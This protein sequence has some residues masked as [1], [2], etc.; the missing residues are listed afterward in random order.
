MVQ[1]LIPNLSVLISNEFGLSSHPCT[2]YTKRNKETLSPHAC[3]RE[4]ACVYNKKYENGSYWEYVD[5]E[6]KIFP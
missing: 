1:R 3:S 5:N 2:E 6:M 4:W